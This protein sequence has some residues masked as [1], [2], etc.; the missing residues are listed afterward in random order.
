[1]RPAPK[2]KNRR[3]SGV[4]EAVTTQSFHARFPEL[5]GRIYDCVLSPA[6][7]DDVLN[8]IRAELGFV[9]AVLAMNALDGRASFFASACMVPGEL[10]AANELY[11]AEIISLWG[12]SRIRHYPLGEP[13]VLSRVCSVETMHGSRYYLEWC[14]DRN[15]GDAV[16]IRVTD[17]PVRYGNVTFGQPDTRGLVDD[18]QVE[19]MRLLAPHFRRAVAINNVLDIKTVEASTFAATVDALQSGVILVD[20]GCGLVYANP[21]AEQ[22]LAKGE[23]LQARHGTVTTGGEMARHALIGAVKQAALDE[24]KLGERGLGIPA[25]GSED[26]PAV[27]H[28]LP[29]KRGA[30]RPGLRQRAVAA[31]FVSPAST[32]PEM[33]RVALS[34]LFDL[35]PAEIRVSEMVSEGVPPADIARA[36]GVSINTVRSHLSRVFEK[37]GTKRQAELVRLLASLARHV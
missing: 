32:P 26:E 15:W 7:W 3:P 13:I 1:M 14:R 37:T 33:P 16:A 36:L 34:L 2:P 5:V 27:I 29:L 30:L 6:S 22:M 4:H 11:G 17:D 12:G 18:D 8:D 35:T 9:N 21:T 10:E 24:T 20:E 28:V 23:L 31:L 25:Q 19:A